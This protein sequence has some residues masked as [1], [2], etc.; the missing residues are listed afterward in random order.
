MLG[1]LTTRLKWIAVAAAWVL[2]LGMA[3][4]GYVAVSKADNGSQTAV[5]AGARIAGNGPA[6]MLRLNGLDVNWIPVPDHYDTRGCG[7]PNGVLATSWGSVKLRSPVPMTCRMAELTARWIEQSVRPAARRHLGADV[8]GLHHMAIYDCRRIAGR[9]DGRLSEHAKSNALDVGA[10]VLSD[11]RKISVKD[12][13]RAGG[14]ESRFLREIGQG[15][16]KIFQ[17]VLTP[18]SNRAHHN[19][20]HLDA[21][22]WRVC[23]KSR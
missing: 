19:H 6:C 11:G 21:G 10:F 15:A 23:V 14:R 4:A 9:K 7:L 20:F 18:D 22:R 8:A 13:W 3:I 16:C 12:H 2:L 17:V 1:K 5:S